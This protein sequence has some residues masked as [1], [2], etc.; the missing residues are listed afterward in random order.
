MMGAAEKEVG[1]RKHGRGAVRERG[2][3]V[4]DLLAGLAITGVAATIAAPAAAVYLDGM[5]L[6]SGSWTLAADVQRARQR[7]IAENRT[8]RLTLAAAPEDAETSYVIAPSS[9]A[10]TAETRRLVAGVRCV[11][12]PGSYVEF[13]SRGLASAATTFLLE[14]T[15]GDHASIE[16][17]STGRIDFAS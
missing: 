5:R 17:R 14:T 11:N 16:V 7:A 2:L 15:T 3:S 8:I 6:S 12:A 4:L 9:G 1:V 13:D 10:G